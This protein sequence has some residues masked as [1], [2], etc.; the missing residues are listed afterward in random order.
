LSNRALAHGGWRPVIS[1]FAFVFIVTGAFIAFM[2]L[3][4]I[5]FDTQS[6]HWME[7]YGAL[8]ICFVLFAADLAITWFLVAIPSFSFLGW[9]MTGAALF[10]ICFILIGLALVL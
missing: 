3:A 5:V 10:V 4:Q 1:R 2:V 9:L 6:H 8:S 7:A